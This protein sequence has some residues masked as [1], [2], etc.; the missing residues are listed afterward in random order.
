[1]IWY[2]LFASKIISEIFLG[3]KQKQQQQKTPQQTQNRTRNTKDQFNSVNKYQKTKQNIG[4]NG[5]TWCMAQSIILITFL[6]MLF[7]DNV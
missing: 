3:E 5:E 7:Q 1:M 6:S 4:Y 2:I